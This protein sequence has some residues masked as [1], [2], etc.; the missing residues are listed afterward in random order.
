MI[1]YC[2]IL[3]EESNRT[4]VL[5]SVIPEV[6]SIKFSNVST[7]LQL[8][9]SNY[10]LTLDVYQINQQYKTIINSVGG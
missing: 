8:S 4:A 1:K 9:S 6:I 2:D 5:W 7:S 3:V 10:L